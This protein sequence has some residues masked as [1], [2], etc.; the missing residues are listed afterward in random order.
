[1]KRTVLVT[2][3]TGTLGRDVVAVLRER[4]HD[5]RGLSRSK[6]G[7]AHGNLLTGEGLAEALDGVDVVVHAATDGRKDVAATAKLIEAL[8]VGGR[9]QLVFVSIVGVDR[10]PFGY[11]NDKVTIEGMVA[12]YGGTNFRASQFHDL[13]LTLAK[14]M[15][16]LPLV[17]FYPAFDL[18]PVE[19]HDVAVR[20]AEI[21]EGELPAKPADLSGPQRRSARELWQAYLAKAGKRRLLVPVRLPGKLFRALR[22]GAGTGPGGGAGTWEDYL[23]RTL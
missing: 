4:G 6:P 14:A 15:T 1:M 12:A 23:S 20:L 18:R 16:K 11:Y 17:G 7:F 3:A 2:G 19:V 10:I 9:P 22:S 21:V 5:V 13:V 8:E